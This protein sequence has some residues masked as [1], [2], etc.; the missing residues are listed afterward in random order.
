[1]K[2]YKNNLPVWL[3]KIDAKEVIAFERTKYAY[4]NHPISATLEPNFYE[5]FKRPY[6]VYSVADIEKFFND[7][8]VNE[9]L[10][11]LKS[12]RADILKGNTYECYTVQS[13]HK[14]RV[15]REYFNPTQ[16]LNELMKIYFTN[17]NSKKQLHYTLL[18]VTALMA[19]SPN[20]Q[21][22]RQNTYETLR[23]IING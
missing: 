6:I 13:Y 19:Y 9:Y 14:E 12:S 17:L 18:V 4:D 15:C 3:H 7:S 8:N 11:D 5:A 22:L 20:M 10:I 1:M 23:K 2:I 21:T 16:R